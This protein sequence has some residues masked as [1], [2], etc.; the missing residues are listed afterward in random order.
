[1]SSPK[2]DEQA[3]R[4]PE[5]A[6]GVAVTLAD[7]QEWSLPRPRV[8]FVPD[9]SDLGFGVRLAMDDGGAYQSLVTAVYAAENDPAYIRAELALARHLLLANYDLAPDQIASLLQFSYGDDADATGAAI[10]EAVMGVA[11]GRT[12]GPKASAGGSESPSLPT[13]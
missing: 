11:F 12:D 2:L 8:R 13:G 6:G 5:F 3:L 10:R 9:E 4:R 7:G 1:M